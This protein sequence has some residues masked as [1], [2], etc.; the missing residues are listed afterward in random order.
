MFEPNM[1]KAG[2]TLLGTFLVFAL[3]KSPVFR[4]DRAG[5]AIIAAS[6][7]VATGVLTF[8]QATRTVDYR[9][10]VLLFSMMIV[11]ASLRISGFF[12]ILGNYL[13]TLVKTPKQLLLA[14]VLTSGVLSAF[15]INDVICL[16]FT[17]VVLMLCKRIGLK[18]LPFL[19]GVATSSNIGSAGTLIGNPQNI[20]IGSLSGMSFGSY[21][22]IAFPLALLGLMINYFFIVWIYNQDLQVPLHQCKPLHG[23]HHNYL[24]TKSIVVTLLILVGFLAGLDTVVTASLG[25]AYLLITRRL[26]PDKIYAQIDF[27]LLVIFTGLFVVIGGVEH[28][29]LMAWIMDHLSFIDFSQFSIFAF[30]TVVLSNIFSNVPAVLLLK[31]FIPSA[32]D[33]WWSGLAIFSTLAGNLTLT[34]SIANLIVVEIAKKEGVQVSFL[35]Y[36]K[37]GLPLTILLCSIALAYFTLFLM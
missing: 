17:P 35:D 34:G 23:I 20:L 22:L 21:M 4:I 10:I 7:T 18:P 6:L 8:D 19:M 9:T 28:S 3:G 11:A 25:A 37:V 2:V 14:V 31:F 36:L 29:G 30:L 1:A 13:L 32:G 5:A 15:F 26:K 33:L 16:L 27:N 24:I 12:Q